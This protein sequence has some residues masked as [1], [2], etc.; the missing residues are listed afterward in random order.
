MRK[1]PPVS[2][3]LN[4]DAILWQH[5]T[6]HVKPLIKRNLIGDK[7]IISEKSSEQTIFV[8]IKLKKSSIKN[9]PA[10]VPLRTPSATLVDLRIG[11]HAG[12]DG[13][14][15]RRLFR[16][17]VSIDRRLDL[18]GFTAARAETKLQFFY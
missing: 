10:C 7:P 4:E 2:Q 13:R 15:Q 16:G 3:N 5:I 6:K 8:P 1:K 18:H 14:T 17:N 11:E 9:Q 12:L